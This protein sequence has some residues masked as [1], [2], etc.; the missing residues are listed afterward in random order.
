MAGANHRLITVKYLIRLVCICQTFHAWLLS[1]WLLPNFLSFSLSFSF[2]LFF[3][4]SFLGTIFRWNTRLYI[5][6]KLLKMGVKA[7]TN[8]KKNCLFITIFVYLVIHLVLPLFISLSF[9]LF[10]LFSINYLEKN[11]IEIFL[12]FPTFWLKIEFVPV[13]LQHI[14]LNW[15]PEQKC[16]WIL[17]YF[18]SK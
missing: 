8:E 16:T 10:I 18:F 1:N 9:Y 3:F 17:Y 12:I 11:F 14:F 4:L 7:K 13:P 5:G 2:F 6:E 15:F